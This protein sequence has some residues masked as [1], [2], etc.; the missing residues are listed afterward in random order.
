MAYGVYITPRQKSFAL[1]FKLVPFILAQKRLAMESNEFVFMLPASLL[2]MFVACLQLWRFYFTSYWLPLTKLVNV[3]TVNEQDVSNSMK[4]DV[5][6]LKSTERHSLTS[7]IAGQGTWRLAFF[8]LMPNFRG[9]YVCV[10]VCVSN[11]IMYMLSY[12]ICLY[13]GQKSSINF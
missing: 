5:R 9:R 11:L 3:T 2:G 6:S 12:A 4:C 7:V 10:C 13:W 1:L 8:H